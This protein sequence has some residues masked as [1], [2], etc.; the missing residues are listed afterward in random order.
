M[1]TDCILKLSNYNPFDKAKE[2]YQYDGDE[3]IL[4]DTKLI[5]SIMI[6]ELG[7]A[8]DDIGIEGSILIEGYQENSDIDIVVKG[9]ESI[10]KLQKNFRLL[11]ENRFIK[12]YDKA[13]LSLIFSGRKKYASFN[14]LD[15][16]LEQ[17]QRRTVGLINGR[18]FWMQPIRGD[19]Y[20][21]MRE[22]RR[23]YRLG[24][25]KSNVRITCISLANLLYRT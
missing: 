15:E 22:K 9:I 3:A 20:L 14:T 19:G 24:E 1:Q 23:L 4:R 17:E 8:L 25:I 18:R 10:K 7:I 13:D 16:M 12:L 6:T 5:I 2:L 21:E 11:K